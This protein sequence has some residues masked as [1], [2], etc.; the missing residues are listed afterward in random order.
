LRTSSSGDEAQNQ[1]ARGDAG[2]GAVGGWLDCHGAGRGAGA[3][4]HSELRGM[5]WLP[6]CPGVAGGGGGGLFLAKF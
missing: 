4:T 1:R 3:S 5:R 2:P 6:N